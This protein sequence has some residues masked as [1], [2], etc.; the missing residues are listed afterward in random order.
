MY[1]QAEDV[2]T[3]VTHALRT[4]NSVAENLCEAYSALAAMKMVDA[5]EL[6]VLEAWLRDVEECHALSSCV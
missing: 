4:G 1:Q 5:A 3:I 2:P 6:P